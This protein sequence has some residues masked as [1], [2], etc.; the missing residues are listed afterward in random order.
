MQEVKGG[1]NL[2]IANGS[3]EA[4]LSGFGVG[5]RRETAFYKKHLIAVQFCVSKAASR[6]EAFKKRGEKRGQM[7]MKNWEEDGFIT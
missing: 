1:V 2:N 6:V 4:K 7:N 5:Q 3:A